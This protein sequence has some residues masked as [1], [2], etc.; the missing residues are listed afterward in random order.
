MKYTSSLCTAK[1]KDEST[2]SRHLYAGLPYAAQTCGFD[3]NICTTFIFC[4]CAKCS[5]RVFY[6]GQIHCL[7]Y[8]KLS[9]CFQTI[10]FH[11]R[12]NDFTTSEHCKSCK[13]KTDRSG[14]VYDD[15]I[16][17]LNRTIIDSIY[18]TGKWFHQ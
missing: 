3:N 12:Y 6:S 15:R 18:C 14:T 8:T 17:L 9:R 13:H 1:E 10:L 16:S 7:P 11:I 4:F 2:F 5:N